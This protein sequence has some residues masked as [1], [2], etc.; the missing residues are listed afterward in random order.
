MIVLI[1]DRNNDLMTLLYLLKLWVAA[2]FSIDYGVILTM[3]G[4]CSRMLKRLIKYF[5]FCFVVVKH[6]HD[7]SPHIK[8]VVVHVVL[9]FPELVGERWNI[10]QR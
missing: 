3:N 6:S 7:I 9:V 5:A 2:S 4:I 8:G 10:E 1:F